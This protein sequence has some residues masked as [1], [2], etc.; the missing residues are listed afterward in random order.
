VNPRARLRVAVL[1]SVAGC[2]AALGGPGLALAETG[3]AQLHA[4][5]DGRP[6]A[7]QRVA[8]YFCDDFSS[9]QIHCYTT[10][11]RLESAVT[12]TLSATAVT[13][14][15]V[16][17]YAGF[18]G[19]YMY[20]SQDYTVLATLGWNDRISSFIARNSQSGHFY[21]DWFYGG[22]SYSFCCNQQVLSLGGYDNTF[23]SVHRN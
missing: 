7:L 9:P 5:L 19:S 4:D 1:M 12:A 11:L 23:S 22:T 2:V 8:N 21:T 10:P 6:L 17:D 14:V 3:D 20:M 16:Y 13:Y 18:A 15:T